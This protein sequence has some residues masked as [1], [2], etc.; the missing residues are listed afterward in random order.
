MEDG[1]SIKIA[2]TFPFVEE[3]L[4]ANNDVG[5]GKMEDGDNDVA[6]EV[7]VVMAVHVYV[8]INIGQ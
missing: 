2:T 3:L 1:A 5:A 7:L 4:D 6:R 8:V